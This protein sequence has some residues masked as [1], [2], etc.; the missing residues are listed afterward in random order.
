V[1]QGMGPGRALGGRYRVGS[2][3][4]SG[5]YGSV[6]TA[7]DGVSRREVAVKEVGAAGSEGTALVVRTLRAVAGLDHPNVIPVFHVVEAD[8]V[9]WAV[10]P[11]VSGPSLAGHL[12]ERGRMSG[13]RVR[14]R[15]P[16]RCA[17]RRP[18]TLWARPVG[19]SFWWSSRW[20]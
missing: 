10:M 4:R 11:L 9:V 5:G 19:D 3:V 8:G 20:R 14:N 2:Q 15:P 12:A 17:R 7:Y 16:P 1:V 6:W 18:T 13:E